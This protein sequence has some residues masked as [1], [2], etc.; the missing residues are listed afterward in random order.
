ML[1]KTDTNMM[2]G[3]ILKKKI[4][5]LPGPNNGDSKLEFTNGPKTKSAPLLEKSSILVMKCPMCA[6][7]VC[8]NGIFKMNIANSACINKPVNTNL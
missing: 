2:V 7:M 6:N 3:I 5:E 8:P 4:N 1:T